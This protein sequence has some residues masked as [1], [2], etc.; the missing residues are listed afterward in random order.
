M[1]F[2]P[3]VVIFHHSDILT[4]VGYDKHFPYWLYLAISC[5]RASGT[6]GED[7]FRK[8]EKLVH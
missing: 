4:F 8:P 7:V 5:Q 1:T 3:H 2:L 6:L